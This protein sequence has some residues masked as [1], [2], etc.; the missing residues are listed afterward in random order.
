MP[1]P[2]SIPWEKRIAIFL[3]YRRR[4]KVYPTAQL[5]G[6]ARATVS[7]IVNEFIEMGFAVAPRPNLSPTI[8]ALAQEQHLREVLEELPKSRAP[9]LPHPR[10]NVRAG[11]RPDDA[12][13][14]EARTRVEA[15]DPLPLEET[16]AWHLKGSAAERTINEMKR[17]IQDYDLRCLELWRGI[18]TALEETTRLSVRHYRS[19]KE[20]QREFSIFDVL[21]ELLYKQLFVGQPPR[22]WPDW[23][24]PAEDQP[25]PL[26]AD[27]IEVAFGRPVERQA[28][29]QA[30]TLFLKTQF[31]G[32]QRHA[33]ELTQLHHD[34]QYVE[35]IVQEVLARVTPE[36]VKAGVCPACPFPEARQESSPEG[37]RKQTEEGGDD[38]QR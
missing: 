31:K 38:E 3:D 20:R 21:V 33:V 36:D 5:H 29:K 24:D 23:D 27:G 14:E 18:R 30:I 17:G 22:D 26:R 28:V 32:Y 37:H 35:K 25:A 34:L 12:L 7:R 16:L 6:V 19:Q 1:R 13:R 8:L 2:P 10:D 9:R 15:R 11:L 4:R